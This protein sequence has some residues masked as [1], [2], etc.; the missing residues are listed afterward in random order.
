MGFIS[1]IDTL[2][3]SVMVENYAEDA[4]ALLKDLQS[5]LEQMFIMRS[6]VPEYVELGGVNFEFKNGVYSW[7]YG[8]KCNDFSLYFAHPENTANYPL[9]VEFRQEYL[10]QEG[11][12]KAWDKFLYFL[13]RCGF[14]YVTSKVSRGDLCS[15]TDSDMLRYQHLQY[16]HY[17][18]RC[19]I[20]K[21]GTLPADADS[22]IETWGKGESYTGIRVGKGKP[23]M[24]RIYDKTEEI[25][26][27]NK[28]WFHTIWQQYGLDPKK[29]INIEFEIKR[30]WF[31][32]FNI[33]TVEDLFEKLGSVWYYLTKNYLCFRYH[34]NE[35]RSRRT[36]CEWWE[37]IR[38]ATFDFD[39]S[40]L[41]KRRQVELNLDR[42]IS[43]AMG[44]ITSYAAVLGY[45]SVDGNVMAE[46][47][48]SMNQMAYCRE[49]SMPERIRKKKM[50]K[51]SPVDLDHLFDE[52]G[53]SPE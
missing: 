12:Q 4:E 35:R 25:K 19:E 41:S 2:Y 34:D 30:D 15:H 7:S 11:Y 27:S 26:V 20:T 10:W 51:L 40:L 1:N 6:R 49:I 46:L 36:I 5:R 28:L 43:G 13:G 50:R 24:A 9:Y 14:K 37:E 48:K 45:N 32:D 18:P 52:F 42:A 47:L 29:V 8:L 39:G 23:L 22:L 31:R 33:D 53:I 38:V 44:Y 21:S 3:A 16:L 17:D